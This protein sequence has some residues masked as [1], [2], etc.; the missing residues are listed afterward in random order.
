MVKYKTAIQADI[1]IFTHIP[2]YSGTIRHI[3]ELFWYIQNLGIF[4]TLA[5]SKS[6][7]YLEP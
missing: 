3:Q 2:I 6:G 1:G 4:R 5:Y 7:T